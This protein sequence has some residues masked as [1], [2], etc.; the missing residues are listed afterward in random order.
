MRVT[1]RDGGELQRWLLAVRVAYLRILDAGQVVILLPRNHE[2]RQVSCVYGQEDHSKKCPDTGHEPIMIMNLLGG[3]NKQ[4]ATLPLVLEDSQPEPMLEIVPPIPANK[5]G[6]RRTCAREEMGTPE[7]HKCDELSVST[8][9]IWLQPS[10]HDL[11]GKTTQTEKWKVQQ[12]EWP[13]ERQASKNWC[14]KVLR[15]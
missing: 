4:L 9:I 13:L 1:V 10:Q 5:C 3:E 2:G 14:Q 8:Q 15:R 12:L 7:G 11:Q 6:I